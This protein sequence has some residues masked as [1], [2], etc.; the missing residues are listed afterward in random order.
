M[1]ADGS[2][3]PNSALA[4]YPTPMPINT[5]NIRVNPFVQTLST[6]IFT[7]EMPATARWLGWI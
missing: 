4:A 1:A 5:Q 3:I 2:S 6:T 7:S